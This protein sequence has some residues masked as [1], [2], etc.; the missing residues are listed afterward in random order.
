[1]QRLPEIQ[2]STPYYDTFSEL[3]APDRH[4][5]PFTSTNAAEKA[6]VRSIISKNTPKKSKK[7]SKQGCGGCCKPSS[8]QGDRSPDYSLTGPIDNSDMMLT[9]SEADAITNRFNCSDADIGSYGLL[10]WQEDRGGISIE[11][12]IDRTQRYLQAYPDPKFG[13]MLVYTYGNFKTHLA[14]A[15]EDFDLRKAAVQ[16]MILE[17]EADVASH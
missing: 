8:S 15:T 11:T 3:F 2:E 9:P 17:Y 5:I 16:Y 13:E 7:G 4:Q 1:M 14:L 6:P 12:A 10:Q